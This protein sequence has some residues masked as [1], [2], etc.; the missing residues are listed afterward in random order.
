[1][2]TFDLYAHSNNPT[3]EQLISVCDQFMSFVQGRSNHTKAL[4]ELVRRVAGATEKDK[5]FHPYD[6]LG[7][8]ESLA[9]Q[10]LGHYQS[11]GAV[12]EELSGFCGQKEKLPY[13]VFYVFAYACVREH[14]SLGVML[15]EVDLL[16]RDQTDHK[17]WA[18]L[19]GMFQDTMLMMVP[20][21]A[22]WDE[23]GVMRYS[24]SAFSNMHHTAFTRQLSDYFSRGWD[25]VKK[26]LDDYP[27]M[28]EASQQLMD[29][30][31]CKRVYRSTL[32]EDD[33]IRGLLADK[34]DDVEDG[35]VRIERLFADLDNPNALVDFETRL[36]HV[37]S[38]LD[39]LDSQGT[40]QVFDVMRSVIKD[41]LVDDDRGQL[42]EPQ[43]AV[44][45]LVGLLERAKDYGFNAL[46]EVAAHL[47]NI[48]MGTPRRFAAET[49]LDGG[50]VEDLREMDAS[51]LWKK[52]ALIVADEDYLLSLGLKESHLIELVRFRPTPGIR[53]AAQAFDKGRDA[54]FGQDLGL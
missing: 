7:A 29:A 8:A 49:I 30:E 45:N 35:K 22:L 50:F 32:A 5:P 15:E 21:P 27:R 9:E 39:F 40:D 41:W 6:I 3:P 44:S 42:S 20:R 10:I 36:E 46:D 18:A 48:A 26:I 37:F 17:A 19:Q 33:A 38:V 34:L 23:E 12:A 25:G 16:Y 51:E 43:M 2:P 14:S 11:L 54:V 28:N 4:S 31:L 53:K 52:A 47:P 24:P 1:M 13:Q